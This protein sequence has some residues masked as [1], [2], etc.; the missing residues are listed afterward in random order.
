MHKDEEYY[1]SI[2]GNELLEK[3]NTDESHRRYAEG[4]NKDINVHTV[5]FHLNEIQGQEKLIYNE[6]N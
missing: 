6:I 1:S 2:K 3:H 5:W 4:E